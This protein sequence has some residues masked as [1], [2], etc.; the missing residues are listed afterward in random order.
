MY[1]LI[2]C[3][4]LVIDG[5]GASRRRADVAIADGKI[6]AIGRFAPSAARRALSAEGCVVAPGFIDPHTHCDPQLTLDP[7][8]SSSCF[9]GVT[10]V[11]VGNCG[12]GIA[13]TRAAGREAVKQIFA[14]VE[15]PAVLDRIPWDFETFPE[16]LRSREGNIAGQKRWTARPLGMRA[17]IVIGVPIVIDGE[18]TDDAARPGAVLRPG[19]GAGPA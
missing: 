3:D 4:G 7:F 17:S 16:L 13:P 10:S 2:V 5:T 6:A 15:D 11:V 1:D 12:F 8:A 18:S 9:H 14:R 19:I